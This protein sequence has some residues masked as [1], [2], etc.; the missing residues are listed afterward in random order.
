MRAH[1]VAAARRFSPVAATV[2][3]TLMAAQPVQGAAVSGRTRV[4]GTVVDHQGKPLPGVLVRFEN[5][6][7]TAKSTKAKPSD[8]AGR[9]SH[10][11]VEFGPVKT[12]IELPGYKMISIEAVAKASDG[13]D[14]GSFG[15]DRFS[16]AQ[17]AR[18]LPFQPSGTVVFKVVM[19][20]EAEYARLADEAAEQAGVVADVKSTRHPAEVGRELFEVKQYPAALEKFLEALALEGGEKE[21]DL[22]FALARCH[23]EV[24]D[25][26]AAMAS[27][28]ALEALEGKPRPGLYQY[29]ALIASKQG[30][31][32]DA[33]EFLE[34]E[35]EAT[36][37]PKAGTLAVLGGL[38]RDLG[39]TDK[40]IEAFD[41]ALEKE[42]ENLSSL[43]SAATLYAGKG[44][45]DRAQEYFRRAAEAGASAGK[46]GAVTFYNLGALSYNKGEFK[47]AVGAYEQAIALKPDYALAHRELGYSY[48]EIKELAKARKHFQRYLE[49]QPNAQDKTEIAG[50]V[51]NLPSS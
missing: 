3:L 19:A 22:H 45:K 36:R 44:D 39:E 9:F 10:P 49:L 35:I 21:P 38:Y 14:A 48:M 8:K 5:Q 30:R 24:G 41:Q 12:I 42:P 4:S 50:F 11:L 43:L 13:A 7:F 40:A 17:E 29:R 18:V 20:P 32:R 37:D 16:A 27:L 6:K 28:D 34:Q 47:E 15:P 31:T 51:S 23:Y 1:A 2:I 26:D 33:V 46:E 25:Y